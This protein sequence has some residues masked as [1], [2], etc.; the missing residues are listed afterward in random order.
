M[1]LGRTP[2]GMESGSAMMNF[3]GMGNVAHTALED[4]R[5]TALMYL[6]LIAKIRQGD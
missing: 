3:L 5:N 1:N 2:A 6:K 4:A